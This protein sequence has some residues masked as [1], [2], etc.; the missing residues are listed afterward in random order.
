MSRAE[1]L[2]LVRFCEVG[3]TNTAV[4][5]AVFALLVHGGCPG[6]VASALAFA[7]GAVNGYH[8]NARWTFADRRQPHQGHVRLRYVAVQATG[9]ATSALGVLVA[10]GVLGLAHLVAEVATLPGV[11]VLT[12]LLMRGF[13]F[14]A[15][16]PALDPAASAA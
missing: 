9:S 11:T 13:V 4:T 6:W 2:R 14:P 3:A 7:A 5:L 12:Y 16:A 8:W 1:L 15:P 10:H